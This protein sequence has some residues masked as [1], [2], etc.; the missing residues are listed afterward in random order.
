LFDDEGE[1]SNFTEE[2]TWHKELA[3]LQFPNLEEIGLFGYA[4]AMP[5]NSG[6]TVLH[7]ALPNVR[8]F[9]LDEGSLL[10][11]SFL[12]TL[13]RRC[14]K[15]K[16]FGLEDISENTI[17]ENGIVRFI[18]ISVFLT[19]LNIRRALEES[20]TLKEFMALARD[21][22]LETLDIPDISDDWPE[23]LRDKRAISPLFPKKRHLVTG[24]SD[25]GLA[26]LAQYMP[27]L[28]SLTLSLQKFPPSHT[29][30]ASASKLTRLTSLVIEFGPNSFLSGHDLVHLALSCPEL[31]GLEISE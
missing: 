18:E 11:D 16:R 22:N 27:D 14:P 6:D 29:M 23:S 4:A 19:S 2:A 8:E 12:D 15:L 7:Y 10:S 5:L 24:T 26:L 31:K 17:S 13:S 28:E 9:I 20:W 1:E 3:G 30:L 25:W 21:L